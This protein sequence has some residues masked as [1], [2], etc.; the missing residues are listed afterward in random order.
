MQDVDL[1]IIEC[2]T[3]DNT[4]ALME[5][6]S[7]YIY[8]MDQAATDKELLRLKC[9]TNGSEHT[10]KN[11][12]LSK[13][14]ME[15]SRRGRP[16][17]DDTSTQLEGMER[18]LM[19]TVKFKQVDNLSDEIVKLRDEVV[20]MTCSTENKGKY[21]NDKVPEDLMKLIE[22]NRNVITSLHHQTAELTQQIQ[23]AS[24]QATDVE[25]TVQAT[26]RELNQW[27]NSAFFKEDSQL[28]KDLHDRISNGKLAIQMEAPSQ[29]VAQTPLS[30]EIANARGQLTTTPNSSPPNLIPVSLFNSH[31]EERTTGH[32]D[33]TPPQATSEDTSRKPTYLNMTESIGR[34]LSPQI[35]PATIQSQQQLPTNTY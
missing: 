11:R 30:M 34:T 35:E 16:A 24:R 15:I 8:G 17:S 19:K 28:L 5:T 6:I 4:M 33:S 3:D 31:E 1:T 27:H 21:S 18:A 9:K 26:R 14:C 13:I 2:P 20:S 29:P 7:T 23:A 25:E 12:L 10:K 22:S 32:H